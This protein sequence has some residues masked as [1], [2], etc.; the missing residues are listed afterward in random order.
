L[1]ESATGKVS[2]FT[3][4]LATAYKAL[5]H[6]KASTAIYAAQAYDGTNAII[7]SL[8]KLKASSSIKSLR[9]GVVTQLHKISFEGVTGAISFPEGREP[10]GRHRCSGCLTD[11]GT[12]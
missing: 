4:K 9:S 6:I 7:K 11:A 5:T 1:S 2:F 12:V 10:Q 3:G 8:L